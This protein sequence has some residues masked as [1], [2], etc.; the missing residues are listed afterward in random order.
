MQTVKIREGRGV[1]PLIRMEV[2][3][4]PHIGTALPPRPFCED[5]QIL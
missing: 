3:G 2:S 5:T 4:Q 1:A